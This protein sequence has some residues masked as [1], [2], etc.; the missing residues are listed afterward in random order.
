MLRQAEVTVG[1]TSSHSVFLLTLEQIAIR[2]WLS[3]TE[4]LEDDPVRIMKHWADAATVFV[5]VDGEVCLLLHHTTSLLGV[6]ATHGPRAFGGAFAVGL[7]GIE[8]VVP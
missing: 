8:L 3:V 5:R 7:D 4:Q 1:L 6:L 2:V